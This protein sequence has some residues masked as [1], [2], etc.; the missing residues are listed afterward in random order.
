MQ[1]VRN[2]RGIAIGI[3][4]MGTVITISNVLVQ[5]PIN[6][7]LTWGHFSFP[8]TFLIADLLNRKLGPSHARIVAY[9]GFVAAVMLS[10]WLATPRIALASGLAFISGQLTDIAVFHRLRKLKWWRA[11]LISSSIAS[12]V[13]TIIF[14]SI[15]FAATGMPWITWAIGDY[16]VKLLTAV[17][18]LLPFFVITNRIWSGQGTSADQA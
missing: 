18:L 4:A 11:P 13:D 5:Y 6:D 3:V 1:S 2:Y 15:A 17:F 12:T 14:Y 7:W 8:I 16:A 10:I 9:A